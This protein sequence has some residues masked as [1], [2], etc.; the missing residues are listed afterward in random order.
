MGLFFLT[1]GLFKIINYK[2]FI[3]AYRRY[4]I[5]A[6]RSKL[7][8]STYP[9][10]EI[11]LGILYTLDLFKVPLNIFTA[12]LMF[13]SLIGVVQTLQSN[14]TIMCACLG[15]VVKLPVTKITLLENLTMGLMALLMLVM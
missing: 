9:F 14:K 5:F 10:I 4:D 15:A 6:K 7:Y 1:F 3:V 13:V 8:A 11:I 2:E 12:I